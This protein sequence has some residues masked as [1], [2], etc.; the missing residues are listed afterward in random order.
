M[1]TFLPKKDIISD[2]TK[3]FPVNI[4]DSL[5]TFVASFDRE[6]ITSGDS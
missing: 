3:A 5:P 2:M 6:K 1:D 4:T